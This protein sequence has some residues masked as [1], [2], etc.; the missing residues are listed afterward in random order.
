MTAERL[1]WTDVGRIGAG[2]VEVHA[3]GRITRPGSMPAPRGPTMAVHALFAPSALPVLTVS[4]PG[5]DHAPRAAA[6]A[7]RVLGQGGAGGHLWLI[8]A[9]DPFRHREICRGECLATVAAAADAL[10]VR[11]DLIDLLLR[12]PVRLR[13]LAAAAG[14]TA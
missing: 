4:P 12:D 11:T 10:S 5:G 3:D 14:L 7:L 8:S 13:G 6:W 2:A 1:L 9:G